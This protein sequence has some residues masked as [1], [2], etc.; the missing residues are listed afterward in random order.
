MRISC[1]DEEKVS[2]NF[3]LL[4]LPHSGALSPITFMSLTSLLTKV[5]ISL[6]FINYHPISKSHSGTATILLH[7]VKP[8]HLPF[9]CVVFLKFKVMKQRKFSQSIP[10]Q[11]NTSIEDSFFHFRIDV[12]SLASQKI[13][14]KIAILAHLKSI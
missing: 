7:S 12:V 3:L 10:E 13:C 6:H 11:A 2:H 14:L 9:M 8:V 1:H 4:F 5:F